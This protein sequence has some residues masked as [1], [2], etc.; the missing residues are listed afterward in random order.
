MT[1][2]RS[3]EPTAHISS[4]VHDGTSI[5]HLQRRVADL[6][7]EKRRLL[8]AVA[9]RDT[10]LAVAAHELRN[11]ITP[12][13]GRIDL[14]RRSLPTASK[15]KISWSLDQLDFLISRFVKR[16]TALLDVSRLNSAEGIHVKSES[17]DV[18]QLAH[19]VVADFSELARLAKSE[20]VIIQPSGTL[21]ASGDPL[22]IEQVLDNLVSNAIKYAPGQPIT[23]EIKSGSDTN[24]VVISV[25]DDGP[26]ISA[27][28][29][30]RI[31]EK[32]ERAV[33]R[34]NKSGG[35]GVGLWVVKQ[36]CEAMNGQ[37]VIDSRPGEGSTFSV[38]L[39][40]AKE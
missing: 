22:A 18:C 23:I 21:N 16:S 28:N 40:A 9:A 17:V 27:E 24:V 25:C 26:G 12:I 4:V 38:S 34:D 36:L 6:E 2:A 3:I 15:E 29:A 10:F 35:F 20:L 1:S 13:V 32:F 11:P 8:D 30:S 19:M 14:L 31:F 39:P 5:E 33:T 7:N 37:I